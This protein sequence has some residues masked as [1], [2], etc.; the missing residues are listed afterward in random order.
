VHAEHADPA[1]LLSKLG[2]DSSLLEPVA[3]VRDDPVAH[4]G[5]DGVADVALLIGQHVVD[6]QE[7]PGADLLLGCRDRGHRGQLPDLRFSKI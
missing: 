3:G 6:A 7:V 4:E 2:R 1:K 5:A